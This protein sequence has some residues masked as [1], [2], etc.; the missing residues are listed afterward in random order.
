MDDGH[1][2]RE[3]RGEPADPD[4]R[5]LVDGREPEEEARDG[6]EVDSRGDHRRGVDEG[7]HGRR[8]LHRV[9]QPDVERELGALPRR[10]AE[11]HDAG[12]R[13]VDRVPSEAVSLKERDVPVREDEPARGP[14][15][16]PGGAVGREEPEVDEH[17]E[18]EHDVPHPGDDE[19]L[20]RGA[21]RAR[22]LVVEADQEVGTDADELPEEEE[23]EQIVGEDEPRHRG[24][25]QRELGVVPREAP[26][27]VHVPDRVEHHE[28]ADHRHD[29]QHQRRDR[30]DQSADDEREPVRE[31]ARGGGDVDPGVLR[32][33]VGRRAEDLSDA[34]Q[35]ADHHRRA[36]EGDRD[37]AA[38]L[39]TAHPGPG[40]PDHHEPDR[41]EQRDQEGPSV[42]PVER[43]R[44]WSPPRI[45]A[46]LPGRR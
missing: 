5:E 2:R 46:P 18:Q 1:G 3:E 8:A 30:V 27:L 28:E 26:V 29:D 40:E 14:A 38:P 41:G 45:S 24:Q 6:E 15:A 32:V 12:D 22:P 13:E 43:S 37:P 11:H 7:A 31:G 35:H 33:R 19:R 42:E 39:E 9:R 20:F 21:R 23:L 16:A 25:E 10:S 4:D 34:D 17:P 44:G 36:R